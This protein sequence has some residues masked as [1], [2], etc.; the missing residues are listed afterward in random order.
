MGLHPT[1]RETLFEALSFDSH[2]KNP[3]FPLE[4][5]LTTPHPFVFYRKRLNPYG[6]LGINL[7]LV[8]WISPI[9]LVPLI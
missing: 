9:A 3:L 5:P 2:K 8:Y 7:Q 4:T 6:T 1:S